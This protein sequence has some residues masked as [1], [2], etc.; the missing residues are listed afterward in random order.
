MRSLVRSFCFLRREISALLVR[1]QCASLLEVFQHLVEAAVFGSQFSEQGFL[2]NLV[3]A[4]ASSDQLTITS[5]IPPDRDRGNGNAA[6][7]SALASHRLRIAPG[8]PSGYLTSASDG[9]MY[10]GA[11]LDEHV[12]AGTGD[13]ELCDALPLACVPPAPANR[14]IEIGRSRLAGV[15]TGSSPCGCA[16]AAASSAG[17]HHALSHRR[18]CRRC[19]DTQPA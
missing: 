9:R 17:R 4:Q 6:L 19:R 3:G 12:D 8:T 11:P 14:E 15:V 5:T 13:R 16:T 2:R 7:Q 1:G 10:D 18:A